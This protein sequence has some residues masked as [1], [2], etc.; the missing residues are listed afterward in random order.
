MNGQSDIADM[1]ACPRSQLRGALKSDVQL[2]AITWFRVGGP[3]RWLFQPADEDDLRHFLQHLNPDIEV[4][5]IGLGSNVL[6]RDRGIDGVVIRLSARG[7]GAVEVHDNHVIDV[8]AATPDMR[9]A[10]RAADAGIAGFSFYR[11]IPGGIGG[12][13]RMNAGAHD[14]ETRDRLI[15]VR[16]VDRRGQVHILANADMGYAYRHSA[17]PSDLIFTQATYQGE[18]GDQQQ[19]QREMAEVEAYRR[20]HQPTRERT[21]GSTFKNPDGDSAWKLIDAAGCRALLVGGAQVSAKHCNF[22]INTGSAT[23]LDLETLGETVRAR[24]LQHSGTRLHWEI[25]R[26]GQWPDGVRVEEFSGVAT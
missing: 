11:G 16:A 5:T 22:L 1:L 20:A 23:A 6:V 9:F 14:N 10:K 24:V 21:G 17:A 25:K 7:F 15:G 13:L 4:T 2:A 19:L 18:P 26:L 8:G 3:A 12:A